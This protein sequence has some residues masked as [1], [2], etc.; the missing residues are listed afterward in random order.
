MAR[1]F[2]LI[3]LMITVAVLAI[4]AAI[5]LPSY[6]DSLRKSRRAQ[7]KADILEYAQQMERFHTLSNSYENFVLPTEDSPR[8]MRGDGY[9]RLKLKDLTASKYTIEATPLS[10]GGQDRDSCGVLSINQAGSKRA[11]GT[12][13]PTCF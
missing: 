4:L 9:Y 6:Q 1:G 2:T 13:D 11:H 12:Q 10:K 8:E 5:A 3:E 7:A